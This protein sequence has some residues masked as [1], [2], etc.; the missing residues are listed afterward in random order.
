MLVRHPVGWAHWVH[1]QQPGSI[2]AY[3]G[4]FST[5]ER[6]AIDMRPLF[7]L[8]QSRNVGGSGVDRTIRDVS[9]IAVGLDFRLF[10]EKRGLLTRP[11]LVACPDI[12]Q[13]PECGHRVHSFGFFPS[14]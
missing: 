12:P 13:G 11:P 7:Q 8:W 5:E 9:K 14:V 4:V 10:L 3:I 2:S 1:S 6:R